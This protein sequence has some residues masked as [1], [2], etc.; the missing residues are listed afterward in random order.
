MVHTGSVGLGHMVGGY[1]GAL[2]RSLYPDHVP[3]PDQFPPGFGTKVKA[4][5][6]ESFKTDKFDEGLQKAIDITLDAKGLGEK[7]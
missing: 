6:L 1:F 7:K 5:M 3:H 2:A 4:A